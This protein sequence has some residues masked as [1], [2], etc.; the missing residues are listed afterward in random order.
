MYNTAFWIE[1]QLNS[2]WDWQLTIQ[3]LTIG[4]GKPSWPSY[5]SSLCYKFGGKA[6]KV[7]IFSWIKKFIADFCFELVSGTQPKITQYQKYKFGEQI[8]FFLS[9]C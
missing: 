5:E 6:K 1:I 4:C 7:A 9:C 8:G 2:L 3:L